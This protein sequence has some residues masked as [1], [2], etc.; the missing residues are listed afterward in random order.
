[1]DDPDL[2]PLMFRTGPA[3]RPAG[4]PLTPQ[5]FR[6]QVLT[7]RLRHADR[8]RRYS[9]VIMTPS[10]AAN[11]AASLR[12]DVAAL[13]PPLPLPLRGGLAAARA[14]AVPPPL[15]PELLAWAQRA[16]YRALHGVRESVQAEADRYRAAAARNPE[17]TPP[18]HEEH[19]RM[20][21]PSR[22]DEAEALATLLR[23]AQDPPREA[24]TALA[25]AVCSPW[26]GDRL[27]VRDRPRRTAP[28][29][30]EFT[31]WVAQHLPVTAG[32]PLPT[33]RGPLAF[34]L[35][36]RT[37]RA[38]DRLTAPP[39][40]LADPALAGGYLARPPR[41]PCLSGDGRL[42]MLGV[43]CGAIPSERADDPDVVAAA[44]TLVE[45]FA[46]P[47]A[48]V[49]TP[50]LSAQHPVMRWRDL[51]QQAWIRTTMPMAGG[52]LAACQRDALRSVPPTWTPPPDPARAAQAA[53]AADNARRAALARQYAAAV[54]GD[55]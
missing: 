53:E 9:N 54:P 38:L 12:A 47:R 45:W 6:A 26:A 10:D 32:A 34:G 5:E 3:P 35:Y 36:H 33:D 14:A 29:H 48:A 52:A 8:A 13:P 2:A 44:T 19:H 41:D 31:R 22:Q 40:W 50:G 30:Q 23:A 7:A 46:G 16:E 39:P 15:D 20:S 17:P 4:Q 11:L 51:D 24:V 37:V 55:A 25:V 1:M 49:L 28:D 21:D 43:L 27:L 42:L 18:E